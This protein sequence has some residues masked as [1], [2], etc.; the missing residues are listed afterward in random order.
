MSKVWVII[1]L[2][3][4]T[5][6][7][8]L[9]LYVLGQ[10]ITEA[11]R[12]YIKNDVWIRPKLFYVFYSKE[13]T[14]YWHDWQKMRDC[15]HTKDRIMSGEHIWAWGAIGGLYV[16]GTLIAWPVTYFILTLKG[17]RAYNTNEHFKKLFERTTKAPKP[18]KVKKTKIIK[19]LDEVA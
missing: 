18:A 11:I 6:L 8:L 1:G 5:P 14:Y 15:G 3:L 9:W 4:A 17:L 10:M 19:G 16:I 12:G 2:V 7:M 13:A